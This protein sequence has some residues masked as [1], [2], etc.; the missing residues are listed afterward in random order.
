[1]PEEVPR[2]GPRVN[3]AAGAGLGVV[4]LSRGSMVLKSVGRNEFM[5]ALLNLLA[6]Y[7]IGTSRVLTV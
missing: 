4:N 5:D 1:M 7:S 2:L 6:E 3:G